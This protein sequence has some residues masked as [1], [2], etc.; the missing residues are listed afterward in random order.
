M[1]AVIAFVAPIMK[2]GQ[3]YEYVGTNMIRPAPKQANLL[4]FEPCVIQRRNERN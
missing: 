3:C 2:F 4:R 1:I